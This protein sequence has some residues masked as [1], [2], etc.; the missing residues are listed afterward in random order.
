[1]ARRG[2]R[3][4]L[5]AASHHTLVASLTPLKACTVKPQ[6]LA[7]TFVLRADVYGAGWPR[8]TFLKNCNML[9]ALGVSAVFSGCLRWRCSSGM[10]EGHASWE[11]AVYSQWPDTYRALMR[12]ALSVYGYTLLFRIIERG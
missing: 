11:T 9:A 8:H 2:L 10:G 1:M 5:R 4:T 6:K 7:A 12:W 3:T